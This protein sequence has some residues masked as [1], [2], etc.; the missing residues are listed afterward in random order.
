MVASLT[1]SGCLLP[2][3]LHDETEPNAPPVFTSA[4][5]A[6]GP[7]TLVGDQRVEL[8]LAA[9]DINTDDN[10]LYVRLFMSTT[11]GSRFFTG[12]ETTLSFPMTTPTDDI[13]KTPRT[14]SFF[15]NGAGQL[16]L[17]WPSGG[18]LYAIVADRKFNMLPLPED[19]AAG[20]FTS[21]EHWD[22]NCK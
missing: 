12:F 2:T 15:S 17:F 14:G 18:D 20:G 7:L 6:F 13:P 19:Q 16:C 4:T 8:D 21:E 9:L 5:P 10:P 3:S 11:P 1:L 22:L